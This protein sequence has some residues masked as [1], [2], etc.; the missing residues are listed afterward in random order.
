MAARLKRIRHGQVAETSA[1]SDGQ[2]KSRSNR[3][4]LKCDD[5]EG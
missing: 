3:P 5:I 4:A 2:T 1:V